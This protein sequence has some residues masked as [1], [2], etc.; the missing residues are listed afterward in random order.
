MKRTDAGNAE[1]LIKEFGDEVIYCPEVKSWYVWDGKKWAVDNGQIYQ[2]AKRVAAI[3][4]KMAVEAEAATKRRILKFAAYCESLAGLKAM[5]QLAQ[6]DQEIVVSTEWFDRNPMILN[7]DNGMLD[8]TSMKYLEFNR[9]EYVTNKANVTYVRGERNKAWEK[10]LA[11]VIPDPDTREFLQTAV[12]YSVTGSVEED[13]MF[14]LYGNGCNGKS[15]FVSTILNLLGSYGAQASS[16]LLMHKRDT[17]PRNDMFVLMGKRFVAAT[18]TGESCQLDENLIKQ[19]TSGERVSVNPKYKS[20][21]EF[22]PTWKTWLST[23]HEPAIMG[24][25]HAIRRRLILIPFTIQ[26]PQ[27]KID[28]RL[29]TY[30]ANDY[31]GRSGILNW[32]LDGVSRWKKHGLSLPNQIENFTKRYHDSQNSIGQF[33][34]DVCVM[35]DGFMI[36]KNTIFSA[37]LNYCKRVNEK[38]RSK[39]AFGRY[40][41]ESGFVE[42]RDSNNRYWVGLKLD[43]SVSIH[44]AD[45]T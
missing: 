42:T 37:Y 25:D 14:I 34:T 8:L 32:V 44:P 33:M 36:S 24:T 29:R 41:K 26:I 30:L 21:F 7:T 20:Q 15:T 23:N 1:L 11:D 5:I 28:T 27:D 31:R 2:I 9:G 4:E 43:D 13:K 19:M 17:G 16:Q 39:N 10:F 22:T 12:G 6:A 3:H 45:A 35:G 40:L 18:E 38:H